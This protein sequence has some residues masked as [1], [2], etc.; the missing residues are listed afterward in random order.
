MPAKRRK[1]TYQ[2]KF[3]KTNLRSVIIII[4]LSI[5]F[6]SLAMIFRADKWTGEDKLS[7]VVKN[8]DQ[9]VSIIVFD[10]VLEEIYKLT[11]PANTEI[12]VAGEYGV[13]KIKSLWS[14]GEQEGFSGDLLARSITMGMK[15]P[16]YAWAD[17]QAVGLADP[18]IA[19]SLRALISDYKSNLV[20]GD[21]LR[22]LIFSSK[23]KNTKRININL[24]ETSFLEKRVLS[25]GEDGY[26]LAQ[27]P[28]QSI[29]AVFSEPYLSTKVVRVSINNATRG[30]G[31]AKDVGS[32]IEVL[33]AKVSSIETSSEYEGV[34]IIRSKDK[35]VLEILSKIFECEEYSELTT[36]AFDLEVVLGKDFVN[37]Y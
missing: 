36:G 20:I 17:W 19:V 11:I 3:K 14:L 27:V 8:S 21:R 32:V 18:G 12:R 5:L 22:L 35:K 7:L 13:W 25:D 15:L 33:G 30:T 37:K 9:S 16:V 1:R 6:F 4:F 2:K 34:C 31:L 26:Q 24:S 29:L 28:P 23:V 10:P